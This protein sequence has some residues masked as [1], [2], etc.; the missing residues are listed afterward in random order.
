M[1]GKK[2]EDIQQKI[3]S[4]RFIE[5]KSIESAESFDTS[6]NT[7]ENKIQSAIQ[8]IRET[9][10]NIN[11]EFLTIK[12]P[13]DFHLE[14]VDF[15]DPL[16]KEAAQIIAQQSKILRELVAEQVATEKIIAARK[17]SFAKMKYEL[18]QKFKGR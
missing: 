13:I 15:P 18:K 14:T 16:P 11:H 7:I 5:G 17:S 4:M 1:N 10:R 6:P 12:T 9:Q 8:D 2:F 3:F